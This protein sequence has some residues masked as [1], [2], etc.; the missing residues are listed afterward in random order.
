ME[1]ETLDALRRAGAPPQI[2][3]AYKRTGLLVTE[4]SKSHIPRDRLS[5]WKAAIDEYFAIEDA[6][7]FAFAMARCSGSKS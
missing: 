3:H 5:E 2:L 1:A 7:F 6:G 4:E